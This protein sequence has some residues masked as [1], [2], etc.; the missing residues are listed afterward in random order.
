MGRRIFAN[1]QWVA[2]V[3]CIDLNPAKAS[4]ALFP[5]FSTPSHPDLPSYAFINP[6]IKAN[7]PSP[8]ILARDPEDFNVMNCFNVF[9]LKIKKAKALSQCHPLWMKYVTLSCQHL[10]RKK[11]EE[12][13][14]LPLKRESKPPESLTRQL[15][16]LS[17][18][19]EAQTTIKNSGPMW[20]SEAFYRIRSIS[21]SPS[22]GSAC[23]P[24][25]G[26]WQCGGIGA[27]R[28]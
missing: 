10:K 7:L 8:S 19:K 14:G 18:S 4:L 11:K 27:G 12:E 3:C 5:P 2:V 25:V 17:S 20:L 21:E 9:P 16:L 15:L 6:G 26:N 1:L 24:T 23:A 13:E 28:S 22:A